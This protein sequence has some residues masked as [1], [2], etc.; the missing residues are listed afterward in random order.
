MSCNS[1]R[2]GTYYLWLQGQSKKLA[3][4]DGKLSELPVSAGFFIALLFD[5]QDEPCMFF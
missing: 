3:E 2:R 4:A 5:P 1:E